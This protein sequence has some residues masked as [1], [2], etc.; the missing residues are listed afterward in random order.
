MT[1][2]QIFESYDRKRSSA[3]ARAQAEHERIRN[4]LPALAKAEDRKKELFAEYI[5]AALSAPAKR[6]EI[7][8][9]IEKCDAEIGEILC[10]NN[11]SGFEPDY[12][13]KLCRDSGYVE[14]NGRK[15]FCSCI[16]EEIYREVFGG[17]SLGEMKGSFGKFDEGLFSEEKEKLFGIESSAKEQIRFSKNYVERYINLYPELRRPNL[18][19]VGEAGLGKTFLMECMARKLYLK[20][21]KILFI[22]S[23]ELFSVFH[24]HRLG[25]MDDLDIIYDADI[26]FLD[27]LGAEPMTQNVTREY[28]L[29]LIEKRLIS[30]KPLIIAT[31]FG[32]EQIAQRYGERVSS[33]LFSEMDSR[34]LYFLGKDLRLN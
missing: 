17:K 27:D 18:M 16:L 14:E 28:F 20:T 30:R 12:D 22:S 5:G 26:I 6:K 23:F 13:C 8:E 19:L 33:R 10:K 15:V 24:K 2:S 3:E 7:W 29:R 4:I 11:L 9:E 25:N 34:K 21:R 1:I 32:E 31:N